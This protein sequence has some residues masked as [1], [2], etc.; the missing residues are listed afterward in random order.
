MTI[1]F[2]IRKFKK[3]DAKQVLALNRELAAFH[4]DKATIT[5][6]QFIQHTFH[7]R[8]AKCFVAEADKKII[9]FAVFYDRPHLG[10][11]GRICMVDLLHTH[12]K[13]RRQG[14]GVALMRHVAKEAI[15]RGCHKL[16][17]FANRR[18]KTS[19]AFYKKID[20]YL[21]DHTSNKYALAGKLLSQFAQSKI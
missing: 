10:N 13:F 15:K 6:K 1:K 7:T 12:E 17:V 20:F 5:P 9:G 19:N 2:K 14:I 4:G 8:L 21:Q 16:E 11:G 18:N 3:E